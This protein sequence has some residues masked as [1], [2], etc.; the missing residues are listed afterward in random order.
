MKAL[1]TGGA[2]FIGSHIVDYLIRSGKPV[3][4]VDN[5]VSGTLDNLVQWIDHPLFE[6]MEIDLLDKEKVN[7]AIIGCDEVYH[8]AANPEVNAKNA[9]PDDHF[10]QNIEA[11]FNLLEAMRQDGN[12]SFITFTSTSTVYGEPE[13]IPTLESY[14]PTIPIS[15]YGASKLA[16]EGLISA[17]ASMYGFRAVI[18]RLA[19]VVGPRSNHG[20]IYDFIG[21]LRCNPDRLEVLGDGTQ[22]K[23]YL[24]IDDCVDGIMHGIRN[25]GVV[26]IF[27]I[28]SEDRTNVLTIAEIVKDELG[29]SDAQISMTGGVDGGR[30]WMGDVK[31]M[32]LDMSRLMQTGWSPRYGS[33]GAV[34]QTVKE[35]IE[36]TG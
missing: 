21:K 8:L 19:N 6:L 9:S 15:L 28:G 25:G 22:S 14:G 2:G 20:V 34:R 16:C 32:Q 30:G 12:Q 7:A 4:V 18:F 10:R 35:M 36:R 24:Y 29:L 26:D 27:N 5:L 13:Q 31:V 11:T 3:R 23:S 17:Y 33:A 1:V